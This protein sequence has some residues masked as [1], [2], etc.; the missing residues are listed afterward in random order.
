[1]PAGA[2]GVLLVPGGDGLHV[3]TNA[4]SPGG[5]HQSHTGGGRVRFDI[6]VTELH[7]LARC[8]T[9]QPIH[10]APHQVPAQSRSPHGQILNTGE[11]LIVNSGTNQVCKVD[12]SGKVGIEM[13]G[14]SSNQQFIR[15]IFS[16]F[17]DPNHLL[18]PGQP[19]Q[20]DGPSDA[21]FWQ[22]TETV[23]GIADLSYHCV[24]ADSGNHRIVDLVYR[25]YQDGLD[26]N[27]QQDPQNGFY[28]PELNWVTC[29]DSL[30]GRCGTDCIQT[31]PIPKGELISGR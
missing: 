17:T 25:V 15:W 26:P 14:T 21:L 9:A 1:M 16:K 10:P 29:T 12:K 13:V 4:T 5:R 31:V 24:V 27:A 22:E 7:L 19:T 23:N 3:F 6:L 11:I 28:L 8:H 2:N 30:Y 18:R 20:L